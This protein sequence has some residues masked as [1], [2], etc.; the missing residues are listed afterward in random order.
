LILNE[1]WDQ[2]QSGEYD[3][4]LDVARFEVLPAGTEFTEQ[5]S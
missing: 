4:A 2:H 5:L 1:N 3:E